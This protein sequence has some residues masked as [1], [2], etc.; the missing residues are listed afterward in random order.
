MPLKKGTSKENC[1][2]INYKELRASGR[3]HEVAQAAALNF[4]G[5]N[6]GGIP[7]KKDKKMEDIKK[8]LQ[9]LKVEV[10]KELE[11]TQKQKEK[12]KRFK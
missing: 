6:W 2:S 1:I 9:K 11:L 12:I 10:E 4:C 3:T 5:K 7:K 8:E